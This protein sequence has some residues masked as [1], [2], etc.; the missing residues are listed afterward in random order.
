MDF[1]K[2]IKNTKST[3]ISNVLFFMNPGNVFIIYVGCYVIIPLVSIN[4]IKKKSKQVCNIPHHSNKGITYFFL[5]LNMIDLTPPP[6]LKVPK[7]F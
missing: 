4:A 6:L 3:F 5:L 1:Y 7:V 2:Y